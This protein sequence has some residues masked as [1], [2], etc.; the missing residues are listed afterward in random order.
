MK[1]ITSYLIEA[2][3]KKNSK[4]DFTH[5]SEKDLYKIQEALFDSS[6]YAGFRKGCHIYEKDLE[7]FDNPIDNDINF[8][9]YLEYCKKYAIDNSIENILVIDGMGYDGTWAIVVFFST[10]P[11]IYCIYHSDEGHT[12][13]LNDTNKN[14]VIKNILDF[15]E[16]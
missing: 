11:Y 15:C 2:L 12:A 10:Q 14:D 4:I 3:I 9:K 1:K 6:E 16:Q 8:V 5:L 13:I 7:W